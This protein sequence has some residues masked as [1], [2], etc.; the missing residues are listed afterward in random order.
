MLDSLQPWIA[1]QPVA[2][3]PYTTGVNNIVQKIGRFAH[4]F[5][6]IA[7]SADLRSKCF[8]LGC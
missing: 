5:F 3:K 7:Y 4:V 1:W 2:R 8:L 6:V